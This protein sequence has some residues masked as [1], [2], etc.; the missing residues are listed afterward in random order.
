[1]T[2]SQ[3][4]FWRRTAAFQLVTFCSSVPYLISTSMFPVSGALQLKTCGM[5]GRGGEG[6]SGGGRV[7]NGRE[8]G[9]GVAG[10]EHMA[11]IT[12]MVL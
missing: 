8:G 12:Y 5:R 4:I 11:E 10:R 3:T 6:K 7:E 1:M 2:E 9:R